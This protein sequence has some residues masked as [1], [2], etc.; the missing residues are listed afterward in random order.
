[1]TTTEVVRACTGQ[2]A[3]FDAYDENP[4]AEWNCKALCFRCPVLYRCREWAV[5]TDVH[6][7]AGALNPQQREEWRRYNTGITVTGLS[8]LDPQTL[9]AEAAP[10]RRQRAELAEQIATLSAHRTTQQIATRLG[11]SERTVVR[12]LAKHRL[13]QVAQ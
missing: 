10:G 12:Y 1:V 7:V 4:E 6:G 11:V 13:T 5:R 3:V 8:M 9:A 2:A